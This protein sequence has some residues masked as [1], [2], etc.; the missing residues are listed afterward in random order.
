MRRL[1]FLAP[2]DLA[3]PTGGYRYDRR[4]LAGLGAL[5][6]RV[7]HH[8]LDASFPVPT[9]P[10]LA[11][12]R[13]VLAAI[14]DG[15]LVVTDGLAFGALPDLAETHR[16]RL[17]LVALVHHPLAEETGLPRD[18]ALRL[19]QSEARALRQARMVLVTSQATA[20]L[21]AGYGVRPGCIRVVEPGTDPAAA[22]CEPRPDRRDGILRL[23]CVAALVP[24]KGHDLLLRA[25]A[26]IQGPPWHLHCVGSPDRDR[27]WADALLRLRGE[28]GLDERVT[29]AG[30]ISELALECRYAESD[31]FVLATR[32][33]GFGMAV[34]EALAR[35]LPILATGCGA[36]AQTVPPGAGILVPPDDPAA[37]SAAL[38]R[39]MNDAALRRR[40]AV[41]ARAAGQR[42]RTWPQVAAAFAAAC[43]EVLR[44]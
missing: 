27:A 34:A 4:V 16:E 32:F 8:R 40:L 31:L 6:W 20:S 43:E 25:L 10:A 41:G 1:W 38:R 30:A 17:R 2:G 35:G 7:E 23:L 39:L 19:R 26:G 37:L 9:P 24:R 5:G 29:F 44:G 21:V 22:A 18:L 3:T 15:R 42:L 12:A 13:S 14:P 11:D 33:E 28:L 36:M